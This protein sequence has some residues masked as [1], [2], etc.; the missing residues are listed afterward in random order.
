MR[1]SKAIA[2][3]E[4]RR[5]CSS[6]GPVRTS[7][8]L[9]GDCD[10][11]P[12][13]RSLCEQHVQRP[14]ECA[15]RRRL[16][17]F[18]DLVLRLIELVSER[19]RRSKAIATLT[20]TAS[21]GLVSKVRTSAPLEG[22]CDISN[23]LHPSRMRRYHPN[24]CAARRRL[25]QLYCRDVAEID[26]FLRP[27]E[28][29][30]RRRLRHLLPP[31]LRHQRQGKSERVRRSKAI[32]TETT[33]LTTNLTM[34]ESERV[35]RSKAIA[36]STERWWRVRYGVRTS[37]PLEGDCDYQGEPYWAFRSGG[38]ERP[39][40]C[41]ARRQLRRESR[42]RERDHRGVRTSAPLEGDCDNQP[43]CLR[44]NSRISPSERVRR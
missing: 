44:S 9:E 4:S 37:A 27:N 33:K 28:C 31:H 42:C 18:D 16:R 10:G 22:D 34:Y 13:D 1:R 5:L 8:P 21:L 26:V 6:F 23:N 38:F 19:V 30:A 15:A 12:S 32:A 35:R 39:N 29:S 41:A 3:C 24:E 25:R 11:K 2:T 20:R 14:D 43:V 40:E 17:H 7:A 36:T